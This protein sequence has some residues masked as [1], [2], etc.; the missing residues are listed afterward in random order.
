M[1]NIGWPEL[2]IIGVV[3]LLVVGPKDLPRVLRSVGH[4][5]GKAKAIT[6]EFRGHV[7]DMIRES[8]LEDVRDQ[9]ND[10]TDSSL[11]TLKENSIYPGELD[12]LGY[13]GDEQRA[14]GDVSAGD[15][16]CALNGGEDNNTE[17]PNQQ[18]NATTS[19]GAETETSSRAAEPDEVGGAEKRENIAS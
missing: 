11:E 7:D 15:A 1:F 12:D 9:I 10:A 18:V 4:Y 13:F 5:A 14:E 19:S 17:A 16:Y 8:E 3:V 2:F 6:R